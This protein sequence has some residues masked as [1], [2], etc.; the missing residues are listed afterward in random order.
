MKINTNIKATPFSDEGKAIVGKEALKFVTDGIKQLMDLMVGDNL[1]FDS[2]RIFSLTMAVIGVAAAF[3]NLTAHVV[4][5]Q[6]ELNH[7][8]ERVQTLEAWVTKCEKEDAEFAEGYKALGK[9]K[10]ETKS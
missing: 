5:L 6:A 7:Y 4:L 10:Y 1:A 2:R 8:R 3:S 9:E